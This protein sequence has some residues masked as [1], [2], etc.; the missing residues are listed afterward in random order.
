MADWLRL[1]ELL[2]ERA[3]ELLDGLGFPERYSDILRAFADSSPPD[4]PPIERELRIESL[5]RLADL[6]PELSEQAWDQ[7]DQARL[8]DHHAGAPDGATTARA[9]RSTACCATSRARRAAPAC[10]RSRCSD[11]RRRG[12]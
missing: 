3:P 7:L 1:A 10:A 5:E 4:E 11:R 2:T 12:W 8:R 6:D 9:S